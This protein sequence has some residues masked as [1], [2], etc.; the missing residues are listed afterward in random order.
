M[1]AAADSMPLEAVRGEVGEVVAV[2][3][4]ERDDDEEEQHGELR[5]HHDRVRAR[6]LADAGDQ[7]PGHGEHEQRGRDVHVA[8]LARRQRDRVAQA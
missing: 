3:R 6:R 4:G 1:S 5:D 2:E 8:A 7:H